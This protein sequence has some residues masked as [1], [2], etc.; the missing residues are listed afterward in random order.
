ME[1]LITFAVDLAPLPKCFISV[2]LFKM[3]QFVSQ[4]QK[5]ADLHTHRHGVSILILKP[6]GCP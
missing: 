6:Q 1:L 5:S 4:R 2:H 3:A